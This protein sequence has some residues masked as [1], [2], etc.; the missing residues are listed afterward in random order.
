MARLLSWRGFDRFAA[1]AATGT[2]ALCTASSFPRS[3]G[4]R[5]HRA[6]GPQ[7]GGGLL[8]RIGC[9]PHCAGALA[10]RIGDLSRRTFRSAEPARRPALDAV[11]DLAVPGGPDVLPGG[12]VR[13]RGVVDASARHR[14]SVAPDLAA[15]STG[16]GSRADGGV[17]RAGVGG[18]GGAASVCTWA[19]SDAG[20][21]GLGGGDAPVVPRRL[22]GGGVADADCHCRTTPLGTLGAGR[23]RRGGRGGRRRHA[24]RPPALPGLAELPA[25]LGSALPARNRLA[26]R[27]IGRIADPRCSPPGRRSRWHC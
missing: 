9:G 17:R 15:A 6:S 5:K 19:G 26:R 23:T 1:R 11:A 24:R 21:R 2:V 14:R 3:D 4:P 20:I 22:P 12:R 27:A 18:R 16:P 7:S 25:V 13:R 8:P 10:G